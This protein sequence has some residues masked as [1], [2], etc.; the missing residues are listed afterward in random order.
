[1]TAMRH[2]A[3]QPLPGIGTLAGAEFGP[4]GT[5]RYRLWRTFG[6]VESGSVLFVMLNPSTADAATDDPTIRRCVGFARRWGAGCVEVVNLFAYRATNPDDL[7]D[8]CEA[9]IDVVGPDNDRVIVQAARDADIIVA[10][11]GAHRMAKERARAVMSLLGAARI[12]CLHVTRDGSPRHPLYV[13]AGTIRV[14]FALVS[15]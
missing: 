11:W 4:G 6:R 12:E 7:A 10:A 1:M 3:Q 15:P 8:S 14:P 13:G 2:V 9:G 5:H